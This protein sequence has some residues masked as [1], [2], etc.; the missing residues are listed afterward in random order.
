MAMRTMEPS[1]KG[2]DDCSGAG[3][4]GRGGGG[5][6]GADGVELFLLFGTSA[7]ES[8]GCGRLEAWGL[9]DDGFLLGVAIP[10]SPP[11]CGGFRSHR[12]AAPGPGAWLPREL[13][14]AR[15]PPP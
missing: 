5:A 15:R 9:E 7:E 2:P 8:L 13:P 11:P 12:L 6:G 3:G 10:A 14:D 4:G 1:T